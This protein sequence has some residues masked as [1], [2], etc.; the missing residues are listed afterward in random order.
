MK[1]PLGW[2]RAYVRERGAFQWDLNPD[3]FGLETSTLI[4][5]TTALP[6]KTDPHGKWYYLGDI[7]SQLGGKLLVP[8]SWPEAALGLET[9]T[10]L[11]GD[12]GSCHWLVYNCQSKQTFWT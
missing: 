7:W 6:L 8:T 9:V 2:N 3:P 10:A 12:T 11:D 5:W 1:N 4:H